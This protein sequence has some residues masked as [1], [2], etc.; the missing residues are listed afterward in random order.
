MT[1]LIGAGYTPGM[2]IREGHR[3]VSV[4]LPAA[5]VERLDEL[6]AVDGLSRQVRMRLMLSLGVVDDRLLERV[7]AAA[8][9]ESENQPPKID[10]RRG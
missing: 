6:R 10:P 1:G 5:V 2:G 4:D 7:R 9:R 8:E 3:R